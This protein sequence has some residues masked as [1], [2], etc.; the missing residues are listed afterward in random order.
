MENPASQGAAYTAVQAGLPQIL[1]LQIPGVAHRRMA[2]ADVQ[3]VRP[4]EHAF[5]HRIGTG[6][7]EIIAG[8]VQLLY[9]ERHER[10][11]A[12]VPLPHARDS[13]QEGSLDSA[14]A[15]KIALGRGHEID[16]TE[17]VGSGVDGQHLFQHPFRAGIGDQPI[18][19]DGDS[20]AGIRSRMEI[21]SCTLRCQV[22]SRARAAPAR[23][24]CSRTPGS[25]TISRMPLAISS[26]L[27]GLQ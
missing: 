14:P 1:M 15:Q 23:I 16:Q 22:N 12:P 25:A 13:L 11:K 17:Q 27:P 7:H 6:Q 9:G 4:G 10:Q 20:H 21:S 8:E 19:H 26:G 5:G 2:E 24:C 18:V 3:L